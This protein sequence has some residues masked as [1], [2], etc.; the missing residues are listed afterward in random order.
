M[1]SALPTV[2]FAFAA[3]ISTAA[4]AEDRALPRLPG[5]EARGP[6]QLPV[7]D[8]ANGVRGK[9]Q[10]PAPESD[11]SEVELGPA[12]WGRSAFELP[13]GPGVILDG[14][15]TW[16]T[17][18]QACG[19]M[20]AVMYA[21]TTP[22]AFEALVDALFEDG[23]TGGPWWLGPLSPNMMDHLAI[24]GFMADD[25]MA[26]GTGPLLEAGP[27]ITAMPAGELHGAICLL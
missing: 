16:G 24:E 1:R 20:G 3:S 21:P 11:W 13:E 27:F 2:A 23:R 17:A 7:R 22:S 10:Q 5:V 15:L 4:F 8:Q 6:I 9:L 19:A 12:V 25:R 26:Q 18:A 14:N